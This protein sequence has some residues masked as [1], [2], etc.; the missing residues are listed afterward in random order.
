LHD[1]RLD[2]AGFARLTDARYYYAIY[3]DLLAAGRPSARGGSL[4]AGRPPGR[5]DG[6]PRGRRRVV[7]LER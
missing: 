2:G 3:R 5:V 1:V 6:G 4:A 7:A